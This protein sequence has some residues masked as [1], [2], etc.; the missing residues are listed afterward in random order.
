MEMK[1]RGR[2][3]YATH[4]GVLVTRPTL[5]SRGGAWI[6]KPN[7]DTWPLARP[8]PE[9]PSCKE[10][11]RRV[12]SCS[13]AVD[14]KMNR[15]TEN[16]VISLQWP[17]AGTICGCEFSRFTTNMCCYHLKAWNL[18]IHKKDGLGPITP[19]GTP[20]EA[21]AKPLLGTLSHLVHFRFLSK[22]NSWCR[23]THAQKYPKHLSKETI[24]M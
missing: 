20:A 6:L 13:K 3:G 19:P 4:G 16:E 11:T 24:M 14:G 12:P 21:K 2:G 7:K 23:W 9:L 22:N 15:W 10:N 17:Q 5:G 18:Y 8:R 1:A